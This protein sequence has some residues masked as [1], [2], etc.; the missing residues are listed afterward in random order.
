MKKWHRCPHTWKVT[1][2][3]N[4]YT[5]G[6]KTV[7]FDTWAEADAKKKQIE[8]AL[9]T[10]EKSKADA[11][12]RGR[13]RFETYAEQ[14]LKKWPGAASS[15]KTYR[16][17]LRRHAYPRIGRMML[18]DITRE[19]ITDLVTDLKNATDETGRALHSASTVAGVYIAVAAVFKEA[20]LSKR[21]AESPCVQVELPAVVSAAILIDPPL[22]QLERFVGRFPADWRL[23][24][25]FQY[26][27]GL[28]IG[29]A[30]ALNANQ[31]RDGGATYR[32]AE[33][34]NPE[35]KL[36]PCK[37]RK[38]G[39]FRDV[40]VPGFVQERYRRHVEFF[41]PDKDGYVIPGRKHP[42]VVR[43][44]YLEHFRAAVAAAELPDFM[45]SHYLRHRW[46]SVMLARGV[47]ITHV[48]RWLGHR[49]IQTTFAIYGHMVPTVAAEAR[50]AMDAAFG[51]LPKTV[52]GMG[53]SDSAAPVS[54]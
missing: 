44:S 12:E 1:W 45:T 36:I 27:C 4:G 7:S 35:G 37:W 19:D 14:R 2:R 52:D 49:Q 15:A 39:E 46:A 32:V 41:P 13:V 3:P 8:A 24:S 17:S 48:S 28:R 47:D 20:R 38:T 42:R 33:Q 9:A 43:N 30:L 22:E 18:R 26:G 34:V 53:V 50:A 6:Q 11:G 31:F 16:S 5:G 29:E 51:E 40:P 21:V 25:W 10:G 23:P 54:G